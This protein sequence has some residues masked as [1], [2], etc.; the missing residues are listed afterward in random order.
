MI[1]VCGHLIDEHER[2]LLR[3]CKFNTKQEG[4]EQD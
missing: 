4:A 2:G 1:C 3:S